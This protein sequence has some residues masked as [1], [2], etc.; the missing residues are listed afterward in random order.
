[1]VE[2]MLLV[3]VYLF[4]A[5]AISFLCSV[6]EAVL[7]STTS[8]F[9]SMKK[10]EGSSAADLMEDYKSNVDRP[11]AAILSLNTIAHTIGAAGVGSE[12]T[13]LFGEEYFGIISA[14]LTLLILVFSEIIPKTLGATYWRSLAMLSA[15]IIRVLIFI[16]W[17]LVWLSEFITRL[18]TPA[19]KQTSVSREEV[20]AMVDLG[21]EEGV[22]RSRESHTLQSCMRL[23]QVKARDIMTPRVIVQAVPATMTLREFYDTKE[24]IFTRIPVYG[25][26]KDYVCGY[27]LLTTVLEKLAADEFDCRIADI[28]RPILNFRETSS[29]YDIWEQMLDKK[30]HIA[31]VL[32]EYG[33]MSGIV[34]MEDVIETML[35]VEI[36]DE[37]DIAIDMQKLAR[38]KW[39]RIRKKQQRALEQ[40]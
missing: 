33:G 27:I 11:V 7:L 13:K 18:F 29:V 36:V 26:G 20:A 21:A 34:T 2:Y 19:E 32:D 3:L 31:V 17:P 5:L 35:G 9:I 16:T 28:V 30:E 25:E 10:A 22:F 8:S 15:R 37:N 38:E 4:G 40:G 12:S 14:V 1:M 24:R 39:E 23:S 6:L